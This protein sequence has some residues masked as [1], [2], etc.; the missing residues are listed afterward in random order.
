MFFKAEAEVKRLDQL[1]ASKMK[2]LFLKKQKELE[3]I[4]NKS[5]MEI[6]SR[7]EMEN[8]F[9][10]IRSGGPIM[11]FHFEKDLLFL[12]KCARQLTFMYKRGD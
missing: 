10:L 9:N 6:P 7:A 3:E 12:F 2:E 8:L 1:K 5:H 11:K 4:C